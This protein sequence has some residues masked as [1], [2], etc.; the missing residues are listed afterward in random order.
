MDKHATLPVTGSK[1]PRFF[2]G[3][4]V[5][6]ACFIIQGMG[7]GASQTY[8][9]FFKPLLT[10]FGWSRTTISGAS[11][12]TFIIS[13]LTSIIVG[14][15]N[16]KFGPRAL[17]AVTGFL[18]GLGYLLMS[19]VNAVWQLYLFYGLVFGLGLSSIDVIPLSTMAR[20]F[21]R[22][23]GTMTGIVKVGTGAGQL[24]FPL[25][26]SGLIVTC[27]WR[28]S[29]LAIGTIILIGIV[30]AAQFLRRDPGQMHL[31]P[32]GDRKQ[33]EVTNNREEGLFLSEAIHTRQ[34][35]M[36]C[37]TNL[38]IFFCSL[39]VLIHIVPHTNDI[40]ISATKS[41]G[42]LSTIGGVSMLGRLVM[43][44]AIDR[45]GSRRAMILCFIIMAA[46]LL[47]LQFARELW[48]LYL[49]AVVHGFAHGGFYTI[50]S[51]LTAEL[52]GMSSHGVIFGIVIF[53]G[54]IGGAAGPLLAGYIF[55]LTYSY[56]LDFWILTAF[57]FA[58]LVLISLIKPVRKGV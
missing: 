24:V 49:F 2:Y 14:S 36:L 39:T 32:D 5:A 51:P 48:M 3:Y 22:R 4:I 45:I 50:I 41:A 15:L 28:N 55:D 1:K 23:R 29:Y 47:W 20:W 27:G 11:S 25:L 30:L 37:A 58:G 31:M 46:G 12:V 7:L 18:M 54:T 52:F 57:G 16:D 43:G 56:R 9:V 6:A 26:A 42:V 33:T 21:V 35:W 53:C 40:G 38:T 10:E 17:M 8:G 44:N 34:F 19:Q 13:G